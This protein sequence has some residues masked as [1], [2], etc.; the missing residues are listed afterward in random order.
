M[1]GLYSRLVHLCNNTTAALLV[2]MQSCLLDLCLRLYVDDLVLCAV[3]LFSGDIGRNTVWRRVHQH[4]HWD[5]RTCHEC[6][7]HAHPDQWTRL[8]LR[9]HA[10]RDCLTNSLKTAEGST[11]TDVCWR[12]LDSRTCIPNAGSLPWAS[13]ANDDRSQYM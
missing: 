4:Q 2:L 11:V 5:Q 1:D 7:S 9:V 3:L 8:D 6:K 12:K 10:V 13:V